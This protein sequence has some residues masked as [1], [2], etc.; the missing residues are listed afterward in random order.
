M[1]RWLYLTLALL[2]GFGLGFHAM[3]S[4]IHGQQAAPV[5]L[6]KELSSYRDVVKQVMPAVVSIE[7][8]A[9]VTKVKTTPRPKMDDP[10]IPEEFRR[11]FEDTPNMPSEPTPSHGFGSGFFIDA[12]GVILTNAHVVDGAEQVTV[13]LSDGRKFVSKDIKSDSKTD[14]AIVVLDSKS[15]PFPVLE[16][17]DSDAYEIGD[18]VLAFGAPFGLTGSVTNGI[19]SAKGRSAM[20]MNMYEDFIQ[21]D[22]AINPGNSGGPLI[23]LDG[24][25]VGINSAIKSRTGGFQGVGLAVSSNLA[26]SVVKALRS[27][28]VVRRG[29][30]GVQIRE[31]QPEVGERMGLAKGVGVV[32][33]DVFDNTPGAKGGLKA[34]DIITSIAGKQVRDGRSLQMIV[35][36]L[37]LKQAAP[38]EVFRDGKTQT[39]NVTVEE[40]PRDFGR[41]EVPAPQRSGS[42]VDPQRLEKLGIEIADLT[43]EEAK[44]LGYREGTTGVVIANVN[45][46]PAQEAGLRKGML[47]TKVDGQRVTNAADA[48]TK[49]EAASMERGVLL[50]V[51]SPTGGT[52]FVLVQVRG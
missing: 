35:A 46:G 7:T 50:Q 38:V 32:V 25:V 37:P 42:S 1:K 49:M 23:G 29:Y 16:L 45:A 43:P 19:I 31:L 22:A 27:D 3:G 44:N 39:L 48:R 9:K 6:P 51:Q 40:Q 13:Q 11:F 34:G 41:A 17:S 33:G 2:L 14:L 52:N 5:Q 4:L 36:N 18:R 10:R 28:G 12:S 21:T 26:K 8:R 47:I 15:G 20:A 24:K 30:L